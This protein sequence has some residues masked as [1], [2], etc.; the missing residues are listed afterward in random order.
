MIFHFIDHGI[1]SSGPNYLN[2]QKTTRRGTVS[3]KIRQLFPQKIYKSPPVK[4][5]HRLAY[6]VPRLQLKL[7]EV[8]L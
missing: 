6:S 2:E 5:V 8:K 1:Y 7:G 4:K 3:T